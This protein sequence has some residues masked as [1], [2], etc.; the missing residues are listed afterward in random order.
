MAIA[1]LILIGVAEFVFLA[2]FWSRLSGSRKT[3]YAG[4]AVFLVVGFA[5]SLA[6]D[7]LLQ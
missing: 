2:E 7:A 1:I 6:I 4:A 3:G 5:H